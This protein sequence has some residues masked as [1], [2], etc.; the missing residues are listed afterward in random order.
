MSLYL[1][2]NTIFQNLHFPSVSPWM[3]L[4]R[5]Q[6]RCYVNVKSFPANLLS[7]IAPYATPGRGYTYP[8]GKVPPTTMPGNIP[9]LATRQVK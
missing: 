7:T 1:Q 6:A 4:L 8:P 5:K 2:V 3:R 9:I